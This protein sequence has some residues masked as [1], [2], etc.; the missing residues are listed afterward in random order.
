M[1]GALALHAVIDLIIHGSG[2][3]P[4]TIITFGQPRVGNKEF[5]QYYESMLSLYNVKHYRLTH[6]RDPIPHLPPRN[7][8]IQRLSYR[9]NSQEIF[10]DGWSS[11]TKKRRECND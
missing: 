2:C 8:L 5:V 6:H 1:G 11:L 3:A 9:H 7:S 10:Y 4:N